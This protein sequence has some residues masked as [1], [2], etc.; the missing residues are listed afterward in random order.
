MTIST[1]MSWRQH[2]AGGVASPE[3]SKSRRDAAT[4]ASAESYSRNQG[5]A[6]PLSFLLLA[7][8]III[9][10]LPILAWQKERSK[11]TMGA[12]VS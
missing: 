9:V 8:T 7:R 5:A 11:T 1:E 6:N 12:G 3:K 10:R 4:K 2:L